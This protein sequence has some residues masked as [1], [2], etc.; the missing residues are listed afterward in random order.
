M[1][2]V[3]FKKGKREDFLKNPQ[4]ILEGFKKLEVVNSFKKNDF[5]A[6]KIHFGE[7]DNKSYINPS[8]LVPLVK[9]LKKIETHP[10]L[11]DTNTLYRGKRNNAVEHIN[12]AY[13]H[14]FSKLNIP[15]IIGDGLK[16]NDYMEVKVDKKHFS[17]CFLASILKDIDFLVVLSHFT[18]HI[19]TG[20]G[21][22]IK[23]LGMGC[24]SRRGKL[25][26]HC[27]V[28]PQINYQSCLSCGICAVNCPAEAIKKKEDK[29]VIVEE[30]CI[31]CAQ[32][33]STCPNGSIKIVWSKN[34]QVLGEKMVEYAY[35][36]ANKRKCAYINFCIFITK[37]CD[38]MNKEE[39]GF[40]QDIGILFSDDAVSIDKASID[41]I[42]QKEKKDVL[43]EIHPEIDYL[44]YLKYAQDLGLGEL[45]YQLIEI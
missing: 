26:Q 17:T 21:A 36:V 7:K 12:L 23:N 43:K 10:F 15:I 35:A 40:I 29:F 9:F 11:L 30:N 28:S 1:S 8:L 16:G 24:A 6:L 34:Y 44:P 27:E 25:H 33:I 13:Q 19:L 5:V 2:K 45:D 20:F 38:C 4:L 37:D 39:G 3:F 18:G 32:C 22:A 31:G 42:I 14:G 41:L